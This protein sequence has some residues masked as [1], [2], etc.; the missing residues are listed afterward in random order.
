MDLGVV[1]GKNLHFNTCETDEKCI[2]AGICPFAVDVTT[3]DEL[4]ENGG[5]FRRYIRGRYDKC[6]PVYEC[7]SEV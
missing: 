4:V 2:K 6:F 3:S 5:V 7:E 1:G